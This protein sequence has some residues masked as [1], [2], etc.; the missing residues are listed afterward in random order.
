MNTDEY[1]KEVEVI[2]QKIKELENCQGVAQIED[3][4][5]EYNRLDKELKELRKQLK[6]TEQSIV[7]QKK[8]KS[9][10]PEKIYEPFNDPNLNCNQ[11]VIEI[12]KAGTMVNGKLVEDFS[13]SRD[14]YYA[15]IRL[16]EQKVALYA[17][18][19]YLKENQHMFNFVLWKANFEKLTGLKEK[20]YKDAINGLFYYGILEKTN[21]V[22]R[23]N[24]GVCCK[25]Y[26][27]HADL[28]VDR[29]PKEKFDARSPEHLQLARERKGNQPL[30]C[31]Y[32][33]YL[34]GVITPNLYGVI[35]LNLY[36]AIALRKLRFPV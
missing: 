1:R 9:P 3:D 2:N 10:T 17:L 28:T 19:N 29:L 34:C 11:W 7:L 35:T 5:E 20:A 23:N 32:T 4:D 16:G 18:W 26:I 14:L 30:R 15:L 13:V 8:E 33:L 22:K 12:H 24:K 25:V 27:F 6:K 31:N 21:R 36:G